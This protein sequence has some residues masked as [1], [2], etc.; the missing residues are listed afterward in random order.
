M[1]YIHYYCCCCCYKVNNKRIIA[2][3]N[4]YMLYIN[5]YI[6]CIKNDNKNVQKIYYSCVAMS[7]KTGT[8]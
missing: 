5:I 2:F 3:I 6:L 7:V 4:I 1:H 8:R